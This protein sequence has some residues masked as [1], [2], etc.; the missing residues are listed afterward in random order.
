MKEGRKRAKF[1]QQ[2]T[3]TPQTKKKKMINTNE[4]QSIIREYFENV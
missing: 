4:I 2:C 1:K 3:Q